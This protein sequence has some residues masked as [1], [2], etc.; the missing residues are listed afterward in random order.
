VATHFFQDFNVSS[1]KN[2]E[3]VQDPYWICQG[4]STERPKIFPRDGIEDVSALKKIF[5]WV[6]SERRPQKEKDLLLNLYPEEESL[7]FRTN[8]SNL[9]TIQQVCDLF[10]PWII[11]KPQRFLL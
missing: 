4:S 9:K 2:S 10:L 1:G 5:V 6:L 7:R 11:I 3:S 8:L